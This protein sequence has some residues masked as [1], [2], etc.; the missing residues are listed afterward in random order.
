MQYA[1]LNR[2]GNALRLTAVLM[3]AL[4][5][6]SPS[7][8]SEA[9][10]IC[11]DE[12]PEGCTE[13]AKYRYLVG[14]NAR[15]VQR[16]DGGKAS[17]EKKPVFQCTE[18]TAVRHSIEFISDRPSRFRGGTFY[19]CASDVPTGQTRRPEGACWPKVEYPAPLPP[20]AALGACT[21]DNAPQ[22]WNITASI[23]Y[24]TS[25]PEDPFPACRI[26]LLERA[27]ICNKTETEQE[28]MELKERVRFLESLHCDDPR[29]EGT[30]LDICDD[31]GD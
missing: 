12:P 30:R 18:R 16:Y 20:D 24:P 28:I 5:C 14:G 11:T 19:S 1:I 21:G 25:I 8:R 4:L 9:Q 13:A 15:F 17:F 27:V 10:S 22:Q 6:L 26:A 31:R 29:T 23:L 7:Q 3:A 2:P